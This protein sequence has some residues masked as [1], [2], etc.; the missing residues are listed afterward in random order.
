MPEWKKCPKCQGR[1][2]SG[3]LRQYNNIVIRPSKCLT[4]KFL[5]DEVFEFHHN[6]DAQTHQHLD[7]F[8]KPGV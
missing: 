6:E 7:E 2:I 8:G 5:F 1:I 3:V 4:C